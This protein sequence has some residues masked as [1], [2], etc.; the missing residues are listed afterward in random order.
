[1]LNRQNGINISPHLRE[2]E[3][4]IFR[5]VL[6]KRANAQAVQKTFDIEKTS[7]FVG[8]HPA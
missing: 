7:G 3:K 4:F 2:L 1:M 8:L 6:E 5:I